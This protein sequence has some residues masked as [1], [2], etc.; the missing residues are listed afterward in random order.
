MKDDEDQS[1]YE[2][3]ILEKI[4]DQN[5]VIIEGLGDL[6]G[7]PAKVDKLAEDMAE[8]KSDIKVI[9]TVITDHSA[10]LKDHGK[11]ITA[12]EAA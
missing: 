10:E 7:L 1:H 6:K 3:A 12:L 5:T 8:V 4:R 9:K 2:G 11:R